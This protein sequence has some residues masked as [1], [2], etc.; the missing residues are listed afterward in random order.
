VSR[1][2]FLGDVQGYAHRLASKL[3]GHAQ[4]PR[5]SAMRVSSSSVSD[6]MK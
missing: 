3:P 6:A 1:F 4:P 2:A 5:G